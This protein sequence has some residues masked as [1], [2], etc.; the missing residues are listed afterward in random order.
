MVTAAAF[1][2]LSAVNIHFGET[3]IATL[4]RD[5]G[6]PHGFSYEWTAAYLRRVEDGYRLIPDKLAADACIPVVSGAQRYHTNPEFGNLPGFLWD[7][8]PDSWGNL[9]M[10][11]AFKAVGLPR[12]PTVLQ[13]LAYVGERAMGGLRFRPAMPDGADD[14]DSAARLEFARVK[15]LAEVVAGDACAAAGDEVRLERLTRA[16]GTAGGAHAKCL[17]ALDRDG[18]AVW[19]ANT[20]FLKTRPG[21]RPCLLKIGGVSAAHVESEYLKNC[22]RIEHAYGLMAKAAGLN[23]A[24]MTLIEA[25]GLWHLAIERFDRRGHSRLHHMTYAAAN[26]ELHAHGAAWY[27]ELPQNLGESLSG[28]GGLDGFFRRAVFNFAAHVTDDHLKN[29]GILLSG[30]GWALSPPYDLVWSPGDRHATLLGGAGAPG[31]VTGDALVGLA[32]VCGLDSRE[33]ASICGE[34][35]EAVSRWREFSVASSVEA[36]LGKTVG[37]SLDDCLRAMESAVAR[38]R[39]GIR[40]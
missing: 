8:L 5:S 21:L 17:V 23:P 4:R 16:A 24:N 13:R 6:A 30:G 40:P 15:A 36:E 27:S 32:R 7:S 20:D 25:G 37:A 19:A 11:R 31:E 38:M 39:P 18:S 34:V 35:F 22:T 14:S 26:H 28:I 1:A 10:A 2:D 9:V 33:A 12:S 29:H 3:H